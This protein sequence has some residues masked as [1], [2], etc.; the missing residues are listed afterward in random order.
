MPKQPEVR[1]T[2]QRAEASPTQQQA[3]NRLWQSLLRELEPKAAVDP[4]VSPAIA[5]TEC[6]LPSIACTC[7]GGDRRG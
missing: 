5:C 1:L 6:C 3:W 7:D 4:H 2:I